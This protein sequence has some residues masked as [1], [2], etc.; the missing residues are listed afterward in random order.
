MLL[1]LILKKT[2]KIMHSNSLTLKFTRLGI[3]MMGLISIH[4]ISMGVFENITPGN[5]L[6]MFYV[7]VSTVGYGDIVPQTLGGRISIVITTLFGGFYL[8]ANLISGYKTY[9]D[10]EKESVKM[11]L[12]DYSTTSDHIVLMKLPEND[13][14]RYLLKLKKELDLNE[15]TSGKPIILLTNIFDK[16]GLPPKLADFIL[17]SGDYFRLEDIVKTG[18]ENADYIIIYSDKTEQSDAQT[19]LALNH[20]K[21]IYSTATIVT[22][23][24]EPSNKSALKN[25]G[26]NIMVR[27]ARAYPEIIVRCIEAPGS[28]Q[29]LEQI[30]KNNGQSLRKEDNPLKSELTWKDFVLHTVTQRNLIPS[31]IER[32]GIPRIPDMDEIILLSD[33]IFILK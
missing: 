10:N 15:E 32:N 20:I 6:W 13:T 8:I 17:V 28:E 29:I 26:A 12:K 22:E 24:R 11:G 25:A 2:R 18:A 21:S 1:S 30:I 3:G 23:F 5:A 27:Q 19:L 14:E 7:T 16:S 4:V 33:K 9:I 31:G